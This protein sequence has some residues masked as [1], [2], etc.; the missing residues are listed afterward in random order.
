MSTEPI[1]PRLRKATPADAAAIAALTDD[2][3][4]KYIPLIGRKPQPMTA[5]YAQMAAEHPIWLLYLD[6][7]LAGLLVLELEPEAMLIYSVAV[8][9]DL[10]GR[11]LGRRLLALAEEEALR[12]GYRHIR[13]YTN[14]HF[15]TNIEL[16]RRVGY[17]ETGREEYLGTRL[18]HM[19]KKLGEACLVPKS[20]YNINCD[21]SHAR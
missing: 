3:Y 16:Y 19:A 18:V 11:G 6:D 2:A 5:D 10:Q 17:L 7:R 13:L 20:R 4:A 9:P 8:R 21:V 1:Q 12:A 15:T 14:E